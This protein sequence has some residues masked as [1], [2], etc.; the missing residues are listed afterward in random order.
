MWFGAGSSSAFNI[1]EDAPEDAQF[2]SHWLVDSLSHQD[3]IG[4]WLVTHKMY[5]NV[6][7][8]GEETDE[9]WALFNQGL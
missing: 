2:L 1:A 5:I 6:V 8:E 3:E 4:A 9:F 7:R